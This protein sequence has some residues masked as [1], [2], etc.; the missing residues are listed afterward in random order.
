MVKLVRWAIENAPGMNMIVIAL[1][2]IGAWAMVSM[3]REVFP[4]FELEIILVTVPYPGA[5]PEDVETGVIEK[6]EEVVRPLEGV[7]KVTSIAK[8]SSGFVLL[9]LQNDVKDV[10]KVLSEVDREVARI[11]NF[12]ELAEDPQIQQITF[13]DT[14]IRLAVIGPADRS[15]EAEQRLRLVAED[16]R[17]AVMKLPAVST[18]DISGAK[19]YQIDVEVSEENLRKYGLTLNAVAAKLRRENIELPGGQLKSEGQEV[20]LRANNRSRIGTEIAKLPLMTDPTGA[21]LT[22]GDIGQVS[23]EFEDVSSVSEFNGL[24]AMVVNVKRSKSE[25]LLAMTEAVHEYAKKAVLPTGYRLVV[26]GDTS[27]DVRDRMQLLMSNGIQGLILVFICLA[28]FLDLRLAFWVAMGI[29]ISILGAGIVLWYTGHTL[30]MLSLF[31]FLIVL[32]IVVDDAIVVSEN[33]YTFR[34][35]GHSLVESAVLGTTEVVT[36][37]VA[38]VWTTIL[39]F[40]PMFFVTGVMGKFMAVIPVAV[41]ATL[42]VSLGESIFVLPCH[43]AHPHNGFFK[44]I[45]VLTY[46]LWPVGRLLGWAN[47]KTTILLEQFADKIYMPALRYS[48]KHPV[49]PLSVLAFASLLTLGAIRG[50]IVPFNLFPK[51]DSKFIVAKIKFPDGTPMSITDRA[52]KQIEEAAREVNR[53]VAKEHAAKAKKTIEEIYPDRGLED[54][55]PLVMTFRQVGEITSANG[56]A[57]EQGAV[58]SHA[59]QIFLELHDTTIREINSL[60]FIRRWREKSGEIAGVDSLSFGSVEIGPGGRP[61]EFKL[62][63]PAAAT[64]QLRSATEFAKQTLRD[65]FAG[66]F[67]VSDDNTPGKWEFQFRVKEQAVATGVTPADLGES[68]RNAF[69][70]AEIMR[71]QRG[72]HEVKLMA[73]YPQEERRSLAEFNDM[74]IRTADG[75]RR[76]INELAEVKIQRGFSEIN[77]VDQERS[78][79]ITADVDETQ[80]NASQ[81]I[82]DLNEKFVP[83]LKAQFP[84]VSLIWEGQQQQNRESVESLKVGFTI[85]MIAMFILLVLQFQSYFQPFLIMASIPFGMIGAVWGH[86]FLG[87]PLRSLACLD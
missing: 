1:L 6:I 7:K 44:V 30:N 45:R 86:A 84:K 48:L 40:I 39:A 59:G 27:V 32:G 82:S 22:V 81:I 70:G 61:I 2:G 19:P 41:I 52:T 50:G 14:A 12:P 26:W 25:D 43:L 80:N 63:A 16:V 53:E 46:P 73:R 13:R 68:V 3:R 65:E 58:G 5:T 83:K 35:N 29:P 18:A 9:E 66:V 78:I 23:D 77:R 55:G 31:A 36:S 49:A 54:R 67:D 11:T 33:I 76:P 51:T 37:V 15:I 57:G 64:D 42:L 24:P 21:V 4:E 34:Q 17:D 85:A 47:G 72:R 75:A 20:L 56:P 69:Y 28:L 79:T 71:L 74:E 10:Q 8:E 60:E 87:S 38:S 62:L